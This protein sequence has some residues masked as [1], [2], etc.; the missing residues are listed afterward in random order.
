MEVINGMEVTK[1]VGGVL[2]TVMAAGM[3]DGMVKEG[4]GDG[5]KNVAPLIQPEM[6]LLK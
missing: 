3:A 6:M 1:A 5:P 4:K 2:T